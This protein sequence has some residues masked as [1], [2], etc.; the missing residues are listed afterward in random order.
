MSC[1]I[2]KFKVPVKK[3][4][5]GLSFWLT[6]TAKKFF[7][8]L[9]CEPFYSCSFLCGDS[10]QLISCCFEPLL[11][12]FSPCPSHLVSHL[13]NHCFQLFQRSER[14]CPF[15]HKTL[16]SAQAC[17]GSYLQLTAERR[18]SITYGKCKLL[19]WCSYFLFIFTCF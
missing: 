8:G 10:N 12:H 15:T 7:L 5:P 2:N 18:E 17:I 16:P 13:A 9:L 1:P 4:T 14:R 6:L 11:T 19:A 3:R